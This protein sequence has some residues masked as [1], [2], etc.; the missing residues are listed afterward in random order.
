MVAFTSGKY[1][2]DDKTVT[3]HKACLLTDDEISL[4]YAALGAQY[5]AIRIITGP[6]DQVSLRDTLRNM[7]DVLEVHL[8]KS[9]LLIEAEPTPLPDPIDFSE[10]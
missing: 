10:A 3:Y 8:R 1:I 6:P 7:L 4:I 2:R 9:G 5:D